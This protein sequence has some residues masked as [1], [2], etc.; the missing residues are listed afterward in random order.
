MATSLGDLVNPQPFASILAL[1]YTSPSHSPV[2][3]NTMNKNKPTA[4]QTGE[5][6]TLS[7]AVVQEVADLITLMGKSQLA[8]LDL[9][10]PHVKLTIRKQ[11]VSNAVTTMISAS[12]SMPRPVL[13]SGSLVSQGANRDENHLMGNH[14]EHTIPVSNP[15]PSYHEILSPMAGTFYRSPSPSSPPFINDGDMVKPGQSVCIVEAMKL[16][17]EIKA[18]KA[19][20]IVKILVENAKPVEKGTVLFHIEGGK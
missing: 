20:K 9:E 17:N 4:P 7:S 5:F 3:V 18:D 13:P 19:G 14:S 15:V 12:S 10:M 1:W 2:E 16:M 11:S 8:E 6:S